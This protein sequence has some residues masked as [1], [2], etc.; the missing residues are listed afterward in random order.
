MILLEAG[1]SVM[2]LA[3]VHRRLAALVLAAFTA[4]SGLADRFWTLLGVQRFA[5]ANAF[6]EHAALVG[7]WLLVA[8]HDLALPGA[9]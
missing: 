3:G 1:A 4:A 2:V 5:A 9:G 6:F 8:W 7:G